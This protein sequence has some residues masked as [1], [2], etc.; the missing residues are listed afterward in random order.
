[1][2]I[3][4]AAL[5]ALFLFACGHNETISDEQV[6]E[7]PPSS[8]QPIRQDEAQLAQ[9]RTEASHQEESVNDAEQELTQAQLE[10]KQ[11]E[12]AIAAEKRKLEQAKAHV[13]AA[14][15]QLAFA[16]SQLKVQQVKLRYQQAMV[17][18]AKYRALAKARDPSV[19]GMDADHFSRKVQDAKA[20]LNDAVEASRKAKQDY[21]ESRQAW[22]K[23][24]VQ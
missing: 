4:L 6:N 5:L 8:L 12:D 10:V 18:E 19:K 15:A 23:D 24:E 11:T 3:A 16:H 2:R 17:E 20:D 22:R 13:E 21:E 1:M 7:L 9:T 14:Q